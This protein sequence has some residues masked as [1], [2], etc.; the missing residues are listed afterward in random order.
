MK[1]VVYLPYWRLRG[2]LYS[3]V[4]FQIVTQAV[5]ASLLAVN[6]PFVPSTLGGR[7]QTLRL[8]FATKSVEGVFHAP[9]V[10]F[11]SVLAV[12]EKQISKVQSDSTASQQDS[13]ERAYIGDATSIVYAPFFIQGTTLYDAILQQP[14]GKVPE[15]VDLR[16]PSL[17]APDWTLNF[18]SATCPFCGWDLKGETDACAFICKKCNSGWQPRGKE[19]KKIAAGMV[20]GG[21]SDDFVYMP[22]WRIAPEISNLELASFADLIRLANLPKAVKPE[23]EKEPFVFWTPA[24]KV[25]PS[26][27]L[28]TARVVTCSPFKAAIEEK[29]P[30]G[31][32]H[33]VNLPMAEAIQ[34]LKV[35]MASFAKPEKSIYKRLA[36]IQMKPVKGALV[37][38]PFRRN[39]ADLVSDELGF[40]ISRQALVYG[41][42][43]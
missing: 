40:G 28:R 35:I 12:T 41:K 20:G 26:L 42:T 24:F 30:Q 15:N 33:P 4:P 29:V 8:R 31:P 36:E 38:A 23:W 39:G 10:P 22:F 7:P 9:K 21:E 18:L 11:P 3:V 6:L 37:Y 25:P 32:S 19:F 17:A 13:F 34:T 43:L 2:T 16:D 1:D 27:Y 14:A 5:D